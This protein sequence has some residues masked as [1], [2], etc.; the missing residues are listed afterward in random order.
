MTREK[1]CLSLGKTSSKNSFKKSGI[2]PKRGG[3][4]SGKVIFLTFLKL[5]RMGQFIKTKDGKI[6]DFLKIFLEEVFP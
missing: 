3:G 2:F 6:P 1:W 4:S 5:L